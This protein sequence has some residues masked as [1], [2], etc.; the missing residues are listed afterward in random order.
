MADL[1]RKKGLKP[2]HD[3]AFDW[4]RDFTQ[5]AHD[6]TGKG[7]ILTDEQAANFILGNAPETRGMTYQQLQQKPQR[8]IA[9][10]PESW[11]SDMEQGV[12]YTPFKHQL[13]KKRPWRT[14]TGRQQFYI[15]HPWYIELGE[16]LHTFK[17]PLERR[18]TI[19]RP[20]SD[21][22]TASFA[23]A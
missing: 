5:L 1:A 2:F 7:E 20:R 4:N 9:T 8:F 3:E 13:E 23:R 22:A 12:A 10:D 16:A 19:P 21:S 15:D 14:L 18:T 17:E 11:N 6:W